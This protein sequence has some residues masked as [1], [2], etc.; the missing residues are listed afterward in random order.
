MNFES[1]HPPDSTLADCP[2]C[3]RRSYLARTCSVCGLSLRSDADVDLFVGTFRQ[4]V[5]EPHPLG[6]A[7][8]RVVGDARDFGLR[9]A[10]SLNANDCWQLT[11]D[12]RGQVDDF[13]LI[14]W[15]GPDRPMSVLDMIG[16]VEDH[17]LLHGYET[18]DL[19]AGPEGTAKEI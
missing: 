6:W 18:K 19:A 3:G 8:T 11:C 13:A 10:V 4:H 16:F 2:R 9:D 12:V 7:Y 1:F 5:G 15:R 14:L 17:P